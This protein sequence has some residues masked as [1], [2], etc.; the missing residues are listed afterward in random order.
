[1]IFNDYNFLFPDSENKYLKLTQSRNR[2]N[3]K[4]I[5]FFSF[6]K[7]INYNGQQ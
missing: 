7:K 4:K 5:S 6:L 3:L 1:M 2:I